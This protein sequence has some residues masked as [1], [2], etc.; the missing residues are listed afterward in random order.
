MQL[1]T[2]LQ[3]RV[4]EA[5]GEQIEQIE[6]HHQHESLLQ[7]PIRIRVAGR[8]RGESDHCND[9]G[10]EQKLGGHFLHFT[11]LPH[12]I[13]CRF[14]PTHCSVRNTCC[15]AQTR[16]GSPRS[17]GACPRTN[18]SWC[19]GTPCGVHSTYSNRRG[20]ALTGFVP[21]TVLPG[22]QHRQARSAIV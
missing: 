17:H 22:W 2:R 4:N 21:T 1:S 19:R 6:H 9:D 3:M 5:H 12:P 20:V 13:S 10:E 7:A 18:S 16:H 8:Q 15:L 11:M 14:G